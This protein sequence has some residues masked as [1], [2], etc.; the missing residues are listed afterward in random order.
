[1]EE[2]VRRGFKSV[3]LPAMGA[4]VGGLPVRGVAREMVLVAKG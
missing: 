1:M 3:A 2:A 4:G